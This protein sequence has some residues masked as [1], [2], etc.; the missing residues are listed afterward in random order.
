M[1]FAP[2]VNCVVVELL[3]GSQSHHSKVRLLGVLIHNL[4]THFGSILKYKQAW[5]NC[6]HYTINPVFDRTHININW[7]QKWDKSHMRHWQGKLTE[8]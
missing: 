4:A 7:L 2:K 3:F 5:I 8:L 1:K 6:I